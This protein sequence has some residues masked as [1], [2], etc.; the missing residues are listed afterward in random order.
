MKVGLT[1]IGAE[2]LR[3]DGEFKVTRV[4]LGNGRY[5]IR[6]GVPI[7]K[8]QL[9]SP[10]ISCRV[11]LSE[12]MKNF[13]CVGIKF[14]NLSLPK[15]FF[16]TEYGVFAYDDDGYEVM[17]AY[18]V[19]GNYELASFFPAFFSNKASADYTTRVLVPK[20]DKIVD[21]EEIKNDW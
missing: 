14:D 4:M 21:S 5:L 19:L 11:S 6:E 10:I 16:Y 15:G 2:I 18:A 20:T 3:R 7:R 17:I 8:N 12:E 1:E 13:W 9:V